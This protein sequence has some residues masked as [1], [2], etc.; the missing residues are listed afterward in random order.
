MPCKRSSQLSYTPIECSACLQPLLK[1][2]AKIGGLFASFQVV[3]TQSLSPLDQGF[4]P[5]AFYKS[6]NNLM[7]LILGNIA[8]YMLFCPSQQRMWER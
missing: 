4:I 1:R 5:P 3:H 2:T 8:G 7:L 6:S